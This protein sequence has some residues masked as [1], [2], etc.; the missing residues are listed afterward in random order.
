MDMNHRDQVTEQNMAISSIETTLHKY[1]TISY[2]FRR[3][4]EVTSLLMRHWHSSTNWTMSLSLYL[5]WVNLA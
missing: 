4:V 3:G 5:W 2:I 1:S